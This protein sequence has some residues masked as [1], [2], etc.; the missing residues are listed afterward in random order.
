MT[1]WSSPTFEDDL[2]ADMR[3]HDGRVTAGPFTGK[4]LLVLWTTGARTGERRRAIL[5]YSRD[6]DAYVV[7]GSNA[8]SSAH[9]HWVTN[10]RLDPRVTVE[11]GGRTFPATAAVAPDAE[12]GRLWDRHVAVNP[13]F[14]AYPARAGGRV[15]PMVKITPV[16]G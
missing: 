8:G 13:G 15:I 12:R 14:A 6:G 5:T 4:P 9:A 10:V 3:A 7:A 1:D 11:T 16:E 2:I